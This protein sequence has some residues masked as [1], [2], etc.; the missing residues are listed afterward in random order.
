MGLPHKHFTGK[1]DKKFKCLFMYKIE[2]FCLQ[3]KSMMIIHTAVV[4]SERRDQGRYG[5]HV[6]DGCGI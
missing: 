6:M 1:K 2:Y 4:A 5:G 3:C